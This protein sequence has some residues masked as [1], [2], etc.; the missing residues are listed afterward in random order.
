MKNTFG[1]SVQITD[2]AH[3]DEIVMAAEIPVAVYFHSDDCIPCMTFAPIFDRVSV[4]Y[5]SLMRF[6]RIDRQQNRPLA[7]RFGIQSSPTLLFFRNGEEACSRLS[8]YVEAGDLLAAVET[9]LGKQCPE[10]P[11]TLVNCDVLILGAGPAGLT[12]AIYAARSRLFTAVLETS[13]P[14]GMVAT[15]FQIANY[16]G[17]NGVVRGTDLM[18]NMKTQALSFGAEIHDMQKMVSVQ[19][20]G[21]EKIIET[22]SAIYRAR[23]IIIASG[24]EPRKLPVPQ[25]KEYRSRGIHYCAT[26][27]G[28]LYQDADVMVVGGGISALEEAEFLTRY[29][30]HVTILNRA[31][32]FRAP[33]GVTSHVLGLPGISA[34]YR[35]QVEGVSGDVF[36]ST[37]TL[38]DLKTNKTETVPVEGIFVYIGSQPDTRL[39]G[40]NLLLSPGG[41][42]QAGEDMKT[43]LPGVFVAG[44]IREKPIRQITTAVSDGTIAAIMAERYLAG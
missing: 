16:P 28:A 39:F 10:N 21:K 9:I 41:F 44:D 33:A 6:V 30:R 32:A 31:E 27:D 12:A 37:A 19:L 11:K 36:V 23:T 34:R 13:I 3:F 40:P 1:N 14:G 15:T 29:A 35:C 17:V 5:S 2:T 42:I 18:E 4:D 38:R 8:G 26:C 43:S 25:E 24:A 7:E 22:E 20:E